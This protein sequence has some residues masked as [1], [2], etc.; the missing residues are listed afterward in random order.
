[1]AVAEVPRVVTDIAPVHSLVALVMG[2][3]GTP[4]LLV[5]PGADAHDIQLTPA[6]AR[7]LQ[8]ASL[9]VWIGP[10]MTPWLERA[11]AGLAP[12]APDLA[13]L[14]VPGTAQREAGHAH[15]AKADGEGHDHEAGAAVHD[16]S[17]PEGHDHGADE[18]TGH[19]A[20]SSAVEEAHDH[21]DFDPHAW[22]NPDNAALW[23]GAVAATL[24]TLDPDNAAIYSANAAR[25]GA[26]IAALDAEL[27]ALLQ[28]VANRPFVVAHDAYGHFADHYGLIVAASAAE[29][30]AAD[31]GARHLA[32]VRAVLGDGAI[33]LFPEAGRD[34]AAT[35]LLAEGTGARIGAPLD[36]EGAALT[37]GPALYGDLMRGMAT[38]LAECLAP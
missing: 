8:E 29:G 1:M 16:H 38:A 11:K 22:L 32:E 27:R 14:T 18:G 2:E 34:P 3:V 12:D 10:G 19:D 9:L 24:G 13:L 30:D 37:P 4:E 31:P 36:P 7:T 23:M 25:A 20:A 15:E 35:V 26:D 28:P 5:G 21:G 33:C 17:A 6:A